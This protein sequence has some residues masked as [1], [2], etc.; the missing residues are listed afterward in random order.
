MIKRGLLKDEYPEIY[1]ML[2]PEL[3]PEI[4]PEKLTSGSKKMITWSCNRASCNHHIWPATI[5][6]VKRNPGKGCPFCAGKKFALV[7]V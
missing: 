5:L 4:D 1:S 7:I 2:N 3:N 6:N